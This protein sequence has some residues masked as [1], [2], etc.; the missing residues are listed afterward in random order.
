MKTY[1]TW[2]V[3]K[4][5]TKDSKLKFKTNNEVIGIINNELVYFDTGNTVRLYTACANYVNVFDKQWELVEKPV[6]FM[7]AIN[8]D[9]LIKPK[10]ENFDY[11]GLSYWICMFPSIRL[12]YLDELLNGEWFIEEGI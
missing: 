9:N 7:E 4:M 6:T 5:L 8:S 10:G 2:E 3:I 11:H 12:Q 1:K